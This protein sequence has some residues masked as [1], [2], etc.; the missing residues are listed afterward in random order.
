MMKNVS[1]ENKTG[2]AIEYREALFKIIFL[3]SALVSVLSVIAII[4]FVFAKG[5]KPFFGN[6]AYSFLDFITGLKWDPNNN[7]FGVFYMI[8]GSLL[9]TLGAIVLGVPIGLLTAV[10]IAEIAPKRIVAILKPG[11]EL[12]AGIPSVIYGAFGLG[13]IVPLINKISPTGQGQSLLAV[14]C[15]LTI[16]VLPTIISLS[17]SSL[18]AVPKSYKEAS[19][20]LGA[21]KIQTIF[22]AIVPA[23]RSGILTATVLGI[24]RAIGETMAV[25]M[26]AGNNIGGLPTSIF[27]KIRPLTTNIAMEMGYASGR[28][29]DMLFATGVIL[30]TFIMAINFTLIRITKKLGNEGPLR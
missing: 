22:K 24:G 25:M 11:I 14:I 6:D 1:N 10:F 2:K 20:G 4:V 12:L 28:H 5:L 27:S 30:F 17:E 21:S 15:V 18:R 3:L 23:A 19:Y 9:A 7:V 8:V 26:I 29:Q 16:M 13:V